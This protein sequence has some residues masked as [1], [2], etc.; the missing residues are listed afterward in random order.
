MPVTLS[1]QQRAIV[2]SIREKWLQA[3]SEFHSKERGANVRD[4]IDSAE[5]DAH[6]LHLE[7]EATGQTISHNQTLIKN[8]GVA[9]TDPEFY[10]HPHAIESFLNSIGCSPDHE[11]LRGARKLDD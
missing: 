3:V 1:P 10:R 8:R 5:A 6:T 2:D 7:L 4:L 9:P 11:T